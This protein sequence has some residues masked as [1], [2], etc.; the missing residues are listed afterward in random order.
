VTH[1]RTED[2]LS[3]WTR[4]TRLYDEGRMKEALGL[5]DEIELRFP[6]KGP[7]MSHARACLHSLMGDADG[8]AR[9]A[10]DAV[11]R[12][13]WWSDMRVVDPDLDLVRQHPEFRA[14]A[15]EMAQLRKATRGRVS[16]RPKVKIFTPDAAP[17]RAV[18][19]ALHMYGMTADETSPFW[20]TAASW[21]AV[22]AVPESAVRDAA[23]APCWDDDALAE[24]DACIALDEAQRAHPCGDS[25]VVL[26]GASQG[27]AQAVRLATTGRIP[28]CTGFIAVVGATPL[29]KLG[30]AD[31]VRGWL[32]A[33]ED[34]VL[35]RRGQEALHA[36]LVRRGIDSRLEVVPGLGHWYPVAF[37]PRLARTLDFVMAATPQ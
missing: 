36:E 7:N 22:V 13:W 34:D 5:V 12:G 29:D 21:G 37:A 19:I 1:G 32:I 3:M 35:V 11:R 17:A 6:E 26:G 16:D 25:P 2:Y 9:V 27:A 20:R 15:D 24:R 10:R 18:L 8:A 33:G 4:L 30:T 31:G 14:L 23:G 28:R